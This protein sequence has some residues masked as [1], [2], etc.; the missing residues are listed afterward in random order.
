MKVVIPGWCVST[1]PQV[2]NCA[3]GKSEIPRCAIAH[4]RF[5][6]RM[7]RNDDAYVFFCLPG[8]VWLNI[9]FSP[10]MPSESRGQS[11]ENELLA[12]LA[13]RMR[14][15]CLTGLATGTGTLSTSARADPGSDRSDT[16][17]TC[18]GGC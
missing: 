11:Q 10:L 9:F 12:Q 17:C 5:V 2:R 13:A 14:A 1:R 8:G 3:P 4:L 7:S 6:L 15:A 16:C 18:C